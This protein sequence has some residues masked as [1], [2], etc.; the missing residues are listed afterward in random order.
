MWQNLQFS[1]NLVTLLK[2]SLLENFIFCAVYL[3]DDGRVK[4]KT[5]GTKKI[6]LSANVNKKL[7]SR[8]WVILYPYGTSLERVYKV[9]LIRHLKIKN[10]YND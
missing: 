6:G 7:E 5:K 9:E 8:D 10:E 3:K 4:K 2:N 1:A